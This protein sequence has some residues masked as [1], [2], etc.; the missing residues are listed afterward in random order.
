MKK[1]VLS[2]LVILSVVIVSVQVFAGT[3]KVLLISDIDDTIKVTHVIASNKVE[4][5]DRTI[6]LKAFTGMAQLY[7]L[8]INENLNSTKVVY[9]SNAPKEILNFP[10]LKILPDLIPEEIKNAPIMQIAHEAFLR[11]NKFPQGL[12]LL[13]LDYED[14]NHKINSIRKLV[15]EDK[16]D[17]VI[18][19][20]DNGERDVEIYKQAAKE[21]NVA[22]ISNQT[23]IHQIYV[24]K[25]VLNSLIPDLTPD[26][27]KNYLLADIGKKI[28]M[29]QLAYIT[30]IE[31]ALDLKNK[32]LLNESALN[33]L[34]QKIV[35]Y[36]LN[37]AHY[38]E[39]RL[40]EVTF[41]AFMNCSEHRFIESIGKAFEIA[42]IVSLVNSKCR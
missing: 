25:S 34:N 8:I 18:M 24:S 40:P 36:I 16:P 42:S 35:P 10:I 38:K 7:Q 13:R 21:L 33:W 31:I 28:E 22:G 19:V 12:T 5:L 27:V 6:E 4:V 3:K 32:N 20:G 9:L 1:M 30:P 14:Q 37:E 17:L 41:P 23:Y 26:F 29:N 11:K 15:K 39:S 2:A